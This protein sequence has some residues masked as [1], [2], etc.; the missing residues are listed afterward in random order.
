MRKEGDNQQVILTVA[1]QEEKF[2]G[3]KELFLRGKASSQEME[4]ARD[5]VIKR[6]F[7]KT[8]SIV[9]HEPICIDWR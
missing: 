1:N 6:I 4:Q 3:A 8:R 9:I 5:K 7:S 2:E